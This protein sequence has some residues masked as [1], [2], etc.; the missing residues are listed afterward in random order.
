MKKTALIAGLVL[1]VSILG[2]SQKYAYVDTEYILKNIPAYEAATDQLNELSKQWQKE[3]DAL[4][5]DIDKMYKDFQVEK[6]LL[7]EEMKAK[8]ENEIVAKEKLVKDKQ[9]K[10]F[11]KDG[12]LFKKR[13]ELIKPIQDEVFTAIK[14]IATNE[15]YAVI[16]DT[17][18]S[19]TMLYVDPKYDKSDEVLEKLGFKK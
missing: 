12:D 10:Y 19:L 6:V 18:G 5:E 8:K 15:N 2:F 1:L 16:F 11:G 9:K 7:S 3:I 17:A 4:Y 13:Q 14:E